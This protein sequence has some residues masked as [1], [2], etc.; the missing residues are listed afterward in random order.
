MLQIE[1]YIIRTKKFSIRYL[2]HIDENLFVDIKDSQLMDAS[3]LDYDYLNG[4]ICIMY[5]G[6]TILGFQ[7]WDLVDQLWYYF[8]EA[9]IQ[10]KSESKS[11]FT[12]PDQPLLVSIEKKG[13]DYLTIRIQDSIVHVPSMDFIASMYES[14]KTFFDCLLL[15]FP[16]KSS[17]I[18]I[19]IDQVAALKEAY[20]L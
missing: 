7:H 14:A 18:Q 1:S 13:L 15:L 5:R 6:K 20:N 19:S 17:D 8:I 11:E 10:L 9:L 4:A 16:E 12:F 2:D 3:A